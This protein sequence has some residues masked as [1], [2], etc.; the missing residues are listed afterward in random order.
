MNTVLITGITGQDGSYLAEYLLNKNYEVHGIIRRS[1]SFNTERIDHIFNKLHLHY[2]DLTDSGSINS[3]I[4]NIMPDYIFNLGAQSHV[5]VS[6][7]LPEYTCDVTGLGALRILEA[8]RQNKELVHH[9]K[10]FQ[11]SSSELFGWAFPPQDEETLM[12]PNSPYAIAKMLAYNLGRAYR[13]GY[14]MYICNGITFNHESPR[15]GLTFVTRKITKFVADYLLG[16][17]KILQLGNLNA[18]RDWG[19][20]PEYIEIMYKMMQ[21]P[22]ST[23][24]VIGTG[25]ALSVRDFIKKAFDYVGLPIRFEGDGLN[26]YGYIYGNKKVVVINPTYYRPNEVSWLCANNTKIKNVLNWEPY[27]TVDDLIKIMIDC[28]LQKNGLPPI[29]ESSKLLKNYTWSTIL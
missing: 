17:T 6:Y 26:E 14:G 29:G 8:V 2:G 28:D 27:T 25:I 16:K 1:S 3:L 12:Q 11:A 18:K 21:L 22:N 10:I 5:K 9:T 23:D 24:L 13:A 7:E 15:R 4:N 20:A 19:F